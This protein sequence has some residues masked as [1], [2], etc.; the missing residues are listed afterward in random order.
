MYRML[1]FQINVRAD[2]AVGKNLQDHPASVCGPVLIDPPKS[3]IPERD[4]TLG[5]YY[6]YFMNGAGERIII[7]IESKR[8]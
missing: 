4:L 2:L 8:G 6:D 5:T 1:S 7:N 3:F